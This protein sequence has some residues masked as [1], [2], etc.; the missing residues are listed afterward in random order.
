VREL[1]VGQSATVRIRRGE[2]AELARA[3]W[4]P[5]IHLP[6]SELTI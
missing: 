3:G 6:P 1:N 4:Q 5:D 2:P